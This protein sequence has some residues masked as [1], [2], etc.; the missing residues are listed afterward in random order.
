MRSRICS[1]EII[2]KVGRNKN[3]LNKF[4]LD[5]PVTT[6]MFAMLLNDYAA[7]GHYINERSQMH[8]I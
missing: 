2:F 3:R 1:F 8:I 7:A 6:E 5:S 4:G